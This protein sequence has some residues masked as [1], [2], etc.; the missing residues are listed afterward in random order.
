MI[1]SYALFGGDNRLK[2]T[3]R[4]NKGLNS[5]QC[6]VLRT[7]GNLCVNVPPLL[8]FHLVPPLSLNPF[9]LSLFRV[10]YFK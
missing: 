4:A 1:C 3:T 8:P 9:V 7:I 2:A 5:K 10:I 6:G